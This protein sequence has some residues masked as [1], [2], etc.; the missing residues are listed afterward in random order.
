MVVQTRSDDRDAQLAMEKLCAIYWPPLYA[1]A[2]R[3]GCSRHDAEDA[4]QAFFA[5]MI[6]GA[7]LDRA[8]QEKGRLRSFLLTSFKRFLND[9]RDKAQAQKRGGGK[10]ILSFDAAA[11]EEVLEGETGSPELAFDR[12]WAHAVLEATLGELE[13]EY[14]AK[15]KEAL[16]NELRPFLTDDGDGYRVVAERL[17]MR[18]NAVGVA[19]FRLRKR[20]GELMRWQVMA[21]VADEDEVEGEL[22]HLMESLG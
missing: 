11:L 8:R 18:E 4:T 16:F 12:S 3:S 22:R 21:T 7:F 20:F 17:G 15:G 19:V 9:E 14:R 13:E 5:K 1:F 2:R 6:G 10:E